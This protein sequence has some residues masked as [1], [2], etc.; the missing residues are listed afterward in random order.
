MNT[1]PR[2][3]RRRLR[4]WRRLTLL[5][6]NGDPFLVRIGIDGFRR[7]GVFIHRLPGPDPG[8]DLHDHPWPFATLVLRGAYRELVAEARTPGYETARWWR[9]GSFHR[10]PLTTVHRIVYVEPGT[11]TLVIRGRK[12]RRWGFLQPTAPIARNHN[13]T[14][15]AT[16]RWVDYETYDYAT[17]RPVRAVES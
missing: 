7:A 10:M 3:D 8:L 4:L 14:R 5:G 12:S 15:M 6:P 2:T 13:E 9:R 16:Y 17:R 11:L 1:E